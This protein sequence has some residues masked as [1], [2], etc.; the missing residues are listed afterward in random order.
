MTRDVLGQRIWENRNSLMRFA[1]SIVHNGADAE[2]AVSEAVVRSMTDIGKLRSEDKLKQWL[3]RITANC[4]YDLMRRKRRE[5]A[6]DD[7]GRFDAPVCETP[8][9]GTVY[10]HITRLKP[11]FRQVLILYYYEG[12]LAKEI[13]QVLGISVSTVLMRLSRGRQKLKDMYEAE[14]VKYNDKQ[15]I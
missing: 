2:D 1:L 14:G 15:R 3:L 4:C 11:V 12:F 7:M 8:A 9:E 5:E 6:T 13:A 10:G